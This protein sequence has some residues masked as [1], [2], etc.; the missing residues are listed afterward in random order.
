MRGFSDFSLMAP[1]FPVLLFLGICKAGPSRW[2]PRGS[3]P[4]RV[5]SPSPGAARLA[6]STSPARASP[7]TAFACRVSGGPSES[8]KDSTYHCPGFRCMYRA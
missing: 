3:V 7:R 8:A 4:F 2:R 1:R 5:S 6:V